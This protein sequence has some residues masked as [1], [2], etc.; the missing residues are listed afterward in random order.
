MRKP[1]PTLTAVEAWSEHGLMPVC[2]FRY[3]LGRQTYVVGECCKW[4]RAS[5]ALLPENA[6]ILIAR[7]LAEA[8]EADDRDRERGG[9]YK[10]LGDDCDRRNWVALMEFI[11]EADNEH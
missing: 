7:E 2:A 3:C 6:R 8:I 11:K 5:W 1:K 10:R 9:S 4:L